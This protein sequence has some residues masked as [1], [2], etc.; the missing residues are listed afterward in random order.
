MGKSSFA[1]FLSLFIYFLGANAMAREITLAADIWCPYNCTPGSSKPGILVEIAQRAFEKQGYEVKYVERPWKR[2]IDLVRQGD[3]DGLIG[4]GL[5]ETPDFVFPKKALISAEHTFFVQNGDSWK[6]SNLA[7]LEQRV[8]GVIGGYSYGDLHLKYVEPSA[9][10]SEKLVVLSGDN[11]LKRLTD[12]LL[13]KRVDVIVED[14]LVLMNSLINHAKASSIQSAG[15]YAK[16]KI[17]IAFSPNKP[18]SRTYAQ[19]LNDYVEKM[20]PGEL[21]EIVSRYVN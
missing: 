9:H 7:S 21:E 12:L 1:L 2:A 14:R 11:L 10:K 18:E 8:L 19:I 16:E 17:Y 4:T 6:Y 20:K 13:K 5:D 3:I 15:I